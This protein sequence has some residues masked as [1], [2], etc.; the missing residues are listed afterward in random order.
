MS[1]WFGNL[2]KWA[3]AQAGTAVLYADDA[4][5]ARLRPPVV[6]W[7]EAAGYPASMRMQGTQDVIGW[8]VA[9]AAIAFHQAWGY[10]RVRAYGPGARRGRRRRRRACDRRPR[11]RR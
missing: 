9:P 5:R 6:S 4:W 8:L 1:V 2:H 10:D 7:S 11:A 3:C